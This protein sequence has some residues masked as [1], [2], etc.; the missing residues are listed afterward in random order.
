VLFFFI[1]IAKMNANA[2][3]KICEEEDEKE[4]PVS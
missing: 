4:I 1:K 2:H 3:A